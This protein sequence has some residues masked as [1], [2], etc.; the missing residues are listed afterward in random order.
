MSHPHPGGGHASL[1]LL[2]WAGWLQCYDHVYILLSSGC[3]KAEAGPRVYNCEGG[4]LGLDIS[5]PSL[6]WALLRFISSP[7][8]QYHHP[9]NNPRPWVAHNNTHLFS[10]WASGI[11]VIWAVPSYFWDWAGFWLPEG[12]A[13]WACW[14]PAALIRVSLSFPQANSGMFSGQCKG[15]KAIKSDGPSAFQ[16]FHLSQ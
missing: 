11:Q 1:P 12:D 14:C 3:L 13:G 2:W 6:F 7:W 16:A 15:A 10:P 9:T 4:K 8:S 5:Q